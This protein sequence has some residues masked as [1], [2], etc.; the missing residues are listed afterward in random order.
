MSLESNQKHA[1]PFF[2]T[3]LNRLAAPL[4]LQH[5]PHD[6]VLR[7]SDR[8]KGAFRNVCSYIIQNPVR[9]QLVAEANEWEYCGALIPGYP[10][11]DP[12]QPDYWTTFWKLHAQLFD[13]KA[14]TLARPWF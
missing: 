8:R 4:E 6:H 12:R 10:T 5:Q 1:M 7:A 11:L 13:K 2:R 3:H 14:E 9:A